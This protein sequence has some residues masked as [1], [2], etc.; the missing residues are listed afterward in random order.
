MRLPTA[1]LRNTTTSPSEFDCRWHP[2]EKWP[3]PSPWHLNLCREAHNRAFPG[4]LNILR[5][6]H[7]EIEQRATAAS[8]TDPD[9]FLGLDAEMRELEEHIRWVARQQDYDMPSEIPEQFQ[10]DRVDF[11]AIKDQ[12]DLVAY[13]GKFTNLRPAGGD[14]KGRC[15]LPGHNDKTA[16]MVVH[17]QSRK[18]KCFGCQQ[19]GDIFDFALLMEEK[20]ARD[21]L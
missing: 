9:A 7:A 20:R 6:L 1:L 10:P 8:D 3:E 5:D 15:P 4:Y 11:K 14:F 19:G 2:T 16:S 12:I 18:W 13:I 17:P 21:L